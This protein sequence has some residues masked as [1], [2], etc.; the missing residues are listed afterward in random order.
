MMKLELLD[1]AYIGLKFKYEN[2]WN[3]EPGFQEVVTKMEEERI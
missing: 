1:K 3:L 2:A